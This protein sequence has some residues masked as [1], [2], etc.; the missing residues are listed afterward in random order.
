MKESIKTSH[1]LLRNTVHVR[2]T[3]NMLLNGANTDVTLICRDRK[4]VRVS[5]MLLRFL[6]P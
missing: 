6:A 3:L 1:A 2:E 4:E 5:S